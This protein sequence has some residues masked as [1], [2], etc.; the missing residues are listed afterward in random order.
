MKYEDLSFTTTNEDG[1]EV[2]CDI[3]TV[4][5]N[6]INTMDANDEFVKHYGKVIEVEGEYVL[7]NVTDPIQIEVIKKESQDEIVKYVNDQVQEKLS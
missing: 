7:K 3:L 1:L 6:P 4:V 5:P 2:I